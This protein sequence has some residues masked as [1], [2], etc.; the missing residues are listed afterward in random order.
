MS[1]KNQYLLKQVDMFQMMPEK[2]YQLF[3]LVWVDQMLLIFHNHLMSPFQLK[4]Y[5]HNLQL[6]YYQTNI[7]SFQPCNVLQPQH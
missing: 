4:I 1:L 5:L 3:V 6:R 7:N 2:L